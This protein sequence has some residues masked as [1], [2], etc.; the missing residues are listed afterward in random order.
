[1]ARKTEGK[2]I[3]E[4]IRKNVMIPKYHLQEFKEFVKYLQKKPKV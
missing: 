4:G 3:P 1:M 2:T